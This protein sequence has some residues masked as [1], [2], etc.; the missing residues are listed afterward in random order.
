MSVIGTPVFTPTE[1]ASAEKPGTAASVKRIITK[2]RVCIVSNS[3]GTSRMTCNSRA[4]DDGV[5]TQAGDANTVDAR[6][7]ATRPVCREE[8]A[9]AGLFL[10][11]GVRLRFASTWSSGQY[12]IVMNDL[13]P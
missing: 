7:V 6:V 11:A 4:T 1:K 12:Q 8:S 10:D 13:C 3:V 9:G 5:Y 2:K